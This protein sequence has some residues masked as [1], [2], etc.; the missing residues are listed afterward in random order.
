MTLATTYHSRSGAG[1]WF[2]AVAFL[3][4]VAISYLVLRRWHLFGLEPWM[5]REQTVR[6][7]ARSL[8]DLFRHTV[9]TAPFVAVIALTLTLERLIPA[10]PAEFPHERD[11]RLP[12][13]VLRPLTQMAYPL[14]QLL[15]S[16][17]GAGRLPQP[18]RTP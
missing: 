17:A 7:F 16:R 1:W 13:L 11:V 14:R 5:V 9:L 4:A 6:V 8:R 12:G 2:A 18:A 10:R 3:V 15:R